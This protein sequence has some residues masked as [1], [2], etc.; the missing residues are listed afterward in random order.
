MS[1]SE[2]KTESSIEP[3]S[4]IFLVQPVVKCRNNDFIYI[5]IAIC[6]V[7][8]ILIILMICRTG[9]KA[10]KFSPYIT[11]ALPDIYRSDAAFAHDGKADRLEKP[12]I[13]DFRALF[14]PLSANQRTRRIDPRS[15]GRANGDPTYPRKAA[16]LAVYPPQPVR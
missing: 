6:V 12:Q 11:T 3:K 10:E 13:D 14:E 16:S 1:T 5:S 8:I 2:P 15:A 9:D 7:L 4:R